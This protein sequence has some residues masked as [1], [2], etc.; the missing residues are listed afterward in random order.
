MQK[1]K[2]NLLKAICNS[3]AK[4]LGVLTLAFS[5][6]VGGHV[7]GRVA[8]AQQVP[9]FGTLK[10]LWMK[11][12]RNLVRQLLDEFAVKTASS[13]LR[14]RAR[15]ETIVDLSNNVLWDLPGLR[16]MRDTAIQNGEGED[17]VE[18]WDFLISAWA[19]VRSRLHWIDYGREQSGAFRQWVNEMALGDESTLR[20][21]DQ[22]MVEDRP[23]L[24]ARY[25]NSG[26]NWGSS[27]WVRENVAPWV[28]AERHAILT[29]LNREQEVV[30]LDLDS[31]ML[32]EEDRQSLQSRIDECRRVT[33]SQ[34]DGIYL[35]WAGEGLVRTYYRQM[36]EL[37]RLDEARQRMFP[38]RVRDFYGNRA[39]QHGDAVVDAYHL[40]PRERG[41]GPLA[42][43]FDVVHGL[44]DHVGNLFGG[45][46][47]SK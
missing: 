46:V 10:E 34:E 6:A 47:S 44:F 30:R 42:W 27:D 32:S 1:N 12:E 18:F 37:G 16:R 2:I 39:R 3:V 11:G 31:E 28:E 26:A 22:L 15:C 29:E 38:D 24:F 9:F 5:L 23:R 8:S 13:V 25:Q 20:L 14:T 45:F 21:V 17:A 43:L 36:A 7:G 19:M 4:K 41:R 35:R 33:D 40:V